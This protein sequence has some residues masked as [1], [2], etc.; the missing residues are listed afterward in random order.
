MNIGS[1]LLVVL[2]VLGLVSGA[3]FATRGDMFGTAIFLLSVP[4]FVHMA[5]AESK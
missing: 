4:L 3:L 5:I 1:L 2:A